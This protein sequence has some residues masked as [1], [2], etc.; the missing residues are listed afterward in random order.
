MAF[1]DKAATVSLGDNSKFPEMR[2]MFENDTRLRVP[3][4]IRSYLKTGIQTVEIK[5]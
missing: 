5:T 3:A 2:S 1:L 4:T